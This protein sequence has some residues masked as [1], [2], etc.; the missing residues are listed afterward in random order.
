MKK[1]IG[2]RGRRGKAIQSATDKLLTVIMSNKGPDIK[3]LAVYS[4]K[5]T[6]SRYIALEYG[7]RCHNI[8]ISDHVGLDNG[9]YQY[10]LRVK[11]IEEDCHKVGMSI[12][13][14][15]KLKGGRIDA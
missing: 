12:I 14:Q 1:K 5:K 15:I 6:M 3:Y 7:G 13:S 9:T 2:P 4:C 8:R 10:D 11:E